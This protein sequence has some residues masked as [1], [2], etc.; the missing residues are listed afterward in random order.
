MPSNRSILL[1]ILMCLWLS[2]TAAAAD[3]EIASPAEPSRLAPRQ[4]KL[5]TDFD[6]HLSAQVDE[7]IE[8]KLDTVLLSR[9]TQLLRHQ[10]RPAARHD[11]LQPAAMRTGALDLPADTVQPASNTTCTMVGHTLECVLRDGA[12]R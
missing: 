11:D 12:D 9:T 8:G 1:G 4:H 10:T 3:D 6:Q 5:Q 7:L 2:P